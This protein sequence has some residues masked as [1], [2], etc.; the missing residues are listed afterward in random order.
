M[1]DRIK[2]KQLTGFKE[3]VQN[4]EIT[5]REKRN[6]ILISGLLEDPLYMEWVM[7]NLKNFDDFLKLPGEDILAVLNSQDQILS[8][9]A[10]CIFPDP[11]SSFEGLESTVAP[12]GNRLRDEMSYLK[13]VTPGEKESAKYYMV[14]AARKLSNAETITGFPWNLPSMEVFYTKT[15]K[16]GYVQIT[17][18]NGVTAAEG[19]SLKNRRLGEWKH[20]YETGA[21][22][23]EGEY[24]DGMKIGP[25]HFYYANGNPKSQGIYH[26]DQKQG[27]WKEFARDGS[28]TE[29]YYNLGVKEN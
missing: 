12:I 20:F 22:L 29:A 23:A 24:S 5:S 21:V 17:F 10:K 1:L 7:K 9:F 4:M 15:Y 18:A 19:M 2:K 14:K 27:K 25:W 6:Q 11:V 13:A 8:V 28:V 16:D 26:H 3:F